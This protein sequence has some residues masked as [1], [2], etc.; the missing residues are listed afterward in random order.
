MG[1]D[2]GEVRWCLYLLHSLGRRPTRHWGLRLDQVA[3]SSHF[4]VEAVESDMPPPPSFHTPS[5]V[6][7]LVGAFGQSLDPG[8]CPP[9]ASPLCPAPIWKGGS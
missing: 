8:L 3:S 9:S 1:R 7:S 5:V 2:S 6:A 4:L